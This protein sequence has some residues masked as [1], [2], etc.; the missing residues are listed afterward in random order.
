MDHTHLDPGEEK[1]AVVLKMT[2]NDA[3]LTDVYERLGMIKQ[4]WS[5]ACF[6][7]QMGNTP[8]KGDYLSWSES[9][10][11]NFANSYLGGRTNRNSVGIDMMTS[12]LGT[13]TA[14]NGAVDLFHMEGVTPEALESG[15]DLLKADYKTYV[16]D[17]EELERLYR[18]YPVLWADKNAKPQR[19]FIGCPHNTREQLKWWGNRIVTAIEESGR[20]TVACPAYLFAHKAVTDDFS[21]ENPELFAKMERMNVNVAQNCPAMYLSTPLQSDECVVTNSNKTRVYSSARFCMDDELVHIMVTGK[22]PDLPPAD[23]VGG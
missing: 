10:A 8:N 6:L 18:S 5:C 20:E 23:R 9:S 1:R 13:A 16:I 12:I 21:Q 7:P 3:H 4:A 22:L 19:V 14:S 2:N 11:I 17:D 15:R